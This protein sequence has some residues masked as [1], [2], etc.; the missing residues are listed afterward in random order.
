MG[1]MLLSED[2][3]K[4]GEED[5]AGWQYRWCSHECMGHK[6]SPGVMQTTGDNKRCCLNCM[7]LDHRTQITNPHGRRNNNLLERCLNRTDELSY[8]QT[9]MSMDES[10]INLLTNYIVI[11][12]IQYHT[13]KRVILH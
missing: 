12:Q 9:L 5:G 10:L 2:S 7:V 3:R 4:A 13:F 6:G 11:G 1:L 8:D